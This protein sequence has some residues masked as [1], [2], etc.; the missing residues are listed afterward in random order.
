ML[1]MIPAEAPMPAATPT[2][3]DTPAATTVDEGV[4]DIDSIR[5]GDVAA[6]P[7]DGA[8]NK[9]AEGSPSVAVGVGVAVLVAV[10]V[11]V[12]DTLGGGV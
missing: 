12:G 2:E 5:K 3:I 4:G 8:G 11:A 9:D 7:R 6:G 1:A 10:G